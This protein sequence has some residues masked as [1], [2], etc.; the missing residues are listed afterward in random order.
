MSSSFLLKMSNDRFGAEI[1][2]VSGRAD[3]TPSQVVNKS[4]CGLAHFGRQRV[5]YK[6]DVI[7]I[8]GNTLD[9]E[10]KLN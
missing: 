2:S 6:F 5:R 7:H 1:H 8:E 10:K 4:E 3:K 9:C